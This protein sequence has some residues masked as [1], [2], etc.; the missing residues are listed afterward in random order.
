MICFLW[1]GILQ[2]IE[3]IEAGRLSIAIGK[4]RCSEVIRGF[5]CRIGYSTVQLGRSK[6]SH[7]ERGEVYGKEVEC[8]ERLGQLKA[9]F[10]SGWS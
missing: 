1:S 2:P 7:R 10:S 5:P 6:L 8:V 9:A 4:V 3:G